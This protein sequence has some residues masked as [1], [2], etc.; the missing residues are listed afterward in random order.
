MKDVLLYVCLLALYSAVALH[1]FGGRADGA[2]IELTWKELGTLFALFAAVATLA[3]WSTLAFKKRVGRLLPGQKIVGVEDGE[4][5][6]AIDV[7][8]P[9][10][11]KREEKKP[12]LRRRK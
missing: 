3:R 11:L 8:K 4:A 7:V 9:Q 6:H 1:F 10:L 2:A 12:K 5:A